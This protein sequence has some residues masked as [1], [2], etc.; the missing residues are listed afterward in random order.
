VLNKATQNKQAASDLINLDTYVRDSFLIVSKAR[1]DKTYVGRAYSMDPLVGSGSE[2]ATVI[3]NIF[4]ACPNDSVIQTNLV[5]APDHHAEWKYKQGKTNGSEMVNELIARQAKVISN[6]AKGKLQSETPILSTRRV[7]M[8]LSQPVRSLNDEV[9]TEALN[10]QNEFFGNLRSSG[11]GRVKILNA[12]DILGHYNQFADIYKPFEPV[13]LDEMRELKHQ[14][15]GPDQVMDFYSDDRVGVFNKDTFCAAVVAK[16]YPEE[17]FPGLMSVLSGA[18]F[19]SGNTKDGGG[20]RILT[21][22]IIN[23]T[24][25]VANQR[26]EL[27]RIE[28]AIKSRQNSQPL[29]FKL[30]NED[31]RQA[32]IDLEYMRAMCSGDGDKIVYAST[33]VFAFGT[34]SD[35]ALASATSIKSTMDKL[36]FDARIVRHDGLVRW[37]QALPMNFSPL[38]ADKLSGECIMPSSSAATLMPVYGDFTGNANTSSLNTGSFF[39]TRRGSAHYF[40]PYISES[41][42]N[43]AIAAAPGSGKSFV[44]QYLI[45]NHLAE[46]TNVFLFDNGRSARKFCA[47]V[48]GEFNE[49]EFNDPNTPSLNPFT[50]LSDTEF[51]EQ[52]EMITDLLLLMAFENEAPHPGARIA[53]SEAVRA[54]HGKDGSDAEIRSVVRSLEIIRESSEHKSDLNEVELAAGN[55]IPRLK[56]FLDSPSRGQFFRGKGTVS[57]I[58]QFTVFELG[59]LTGDEHLRKCVLFFVLN[60]LLTR[61]KSIKGRKMIFVDEAHDLF[62]DASAA[63][64]MEG[65]YL[66]GRKDQVG[67]FVVV[68]SLLKLAESSAGRIILNQSAWKLV[69]AQ[70]AEEVERI[71]QEKVMTAFADDPFFKRLVESIE[72]RK[73]Q[74]S[75]ILFVGERYYEC[76]RLY[77]DRFT[78]TLYSSEGDARDEVFNLMDQGMGAVEAVNK[79]LGD[80]RS[81]RMSLLKM[82]VEQLRFNEPL[83][84]DAELLASVGSAL[85]ET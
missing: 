49:F 8:T 69:L 2:L 28:N 35:E 27:D 39:I 23:T 52:Q 83:L 77:V 60:M 84:T 78:S 17:V 80:K 3:Q 22:F 56:A 12:G 5:C 72:T 45:Q 63:G 71:F 40:D 15:F 55:L 42:F 36:D 37:A 48:K 13:I 67:V 9:M 11:F 70:R 75:E 14:A 59:G 76:A 47:A 61:V 7:I 41:N 57:D 50:G 73:G 62:K 58:K 24:V 68:Q 4:K 74:F 64:A 43:G 44:L 16:A 29:P 30:G 66:K 19:N 1:D 26:K 38:L 33:T 65:I 20:A 18:P 82:V 25:R 6:A 85:V 53:M 51:N 46:G 21:P 31:P 81:D 54:A 79:V 32:M 34:T 10:T